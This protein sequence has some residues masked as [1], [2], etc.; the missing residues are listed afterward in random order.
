MFIINVIFSD[1]KAKNIFYYLYFIY[2]V[3]DGLDT[4]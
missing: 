1:M 4:E 2:E 3:C